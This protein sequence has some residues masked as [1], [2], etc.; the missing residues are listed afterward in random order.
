MEVTRRTS[1]SPPARNS[2]NMRALINGPS[3]YEFLYRGM[4]IT[5]AFHCVQTAVQ[6]NLSFSKSSPLSLVKRI[7]SQQWVQILYLYC[8]SHIISDIFSYTVIIM[9]YVCVYTHTYIIYLYNA[10]FIMLVLHTRFL[11]QSQHTQQTRFCSSG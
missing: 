2:H 3:Y 10:I 6:L 8:I 11:E 1:I 4:S 7:R 9:L 5:S